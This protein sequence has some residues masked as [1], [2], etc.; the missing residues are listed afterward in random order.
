MKLEPEVFLCLVI[1]LETV[2]FQAEVKVRFSCINLIRENVKSCLIGC[3]D[4][5]VEGITS[6]CV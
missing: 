1:E 5:E 3:G 4:S 6:D 2:E